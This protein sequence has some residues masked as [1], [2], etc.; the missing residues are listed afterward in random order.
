MIKKPENKFNFSTWRESPKFGGSKSGSPKKVDYSSFVNEKGVLEI[1]PVGEIDMYAEI[2]SHAAE[3]DIN[4][5]IKR[6]Q[7]GDENALQKAQGFF[8]DATNVPENMADMLNKLNRAELEFN[9]L[10]VSIKQKYGNDFTKFICTFNPVD[11]VENINDV[12]NLAVNV[13]KENVVKEVINNEA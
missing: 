8:I 11:L 2:Q 4:M 9:K 1:V 12:N 7:M 6:Y 3:C 10:P 5:I 13:K